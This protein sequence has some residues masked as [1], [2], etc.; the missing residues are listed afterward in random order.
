MTRSRRARQ[1]VLIAAGEAVVA[2][3]ICAIDY[4]AN[5]TYGTDLTITFIQASKTGTSVEVD[6]KIPAGVKRELF[7]AFGSKYK[8]YTYLKT[9]ER[10]ARMSQNEEYDLP[11][12]RGKMIV[13]VTGYQQLWVRL[14]VT[15]NGSPQAFS[16]PHGNHWALNAGPDPDPLIIVFYI[17]KVETHN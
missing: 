16:V 12:D 8:K 13:R 3:A 11:N 2:L 15:V 7:R 14:L 1:G 6:E 9:D 17:K 5:I 4:A 10:L